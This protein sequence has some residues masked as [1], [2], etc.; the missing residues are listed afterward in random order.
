MRRAKV[1]GGLEQERPRLPPL[2]TLS[3]SQTLYFLPFGQ[4]SPNASNMV[5]TSSGGVLKAWLG[6]ELA[7]LL[8][9]SFTDCPACPQLPFRALLRLP[10]SLVASEEEKV[11]SPPVDT[12]RFLSA[13]GRHV[14]MIHL[15]GAPNLVTG[16]GTASATHP[17]WAWTLVSRG[18]D[19]A[20]CPM[21][22]LASPA[23]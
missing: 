21:V 1:G 6:E 2:E 18:V 10:F 16:F 13:V 5:E 17:G 22:V 12:S 4:S 14:H 9:R 8:T 7:R 11:V 19:W 15:P 23:L 3:V 20:C